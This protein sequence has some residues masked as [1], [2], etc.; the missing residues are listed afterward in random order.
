VDATGDAVI[1]GRIVGKK[2]GAIGANGSIFAYTISDA[3]VEAMG[4]LVVRDSIVYSEVTS[5]GR[6]IVTSPQG[7]IFG[8]T[9]A[10]LKEIRAGKI[11][12]DF[13]S[14]TSTVVGK[15]FLTQRRLARANDKIRSYEEMLAKID[16]IKKK[17]S[18]GNV[19]TK[20][21]SAS[22]QDVYISLLQKEIRA[23][24]ELAGHKRAKEKLDQAMKNFLTASIKVLEELN[25]P[26]KV[27][28]CEAVEEIRQRLT[29]VTLVLD[30]QN[31]V[32]TMENKE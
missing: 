1:H 26:V 5:N 31:K 2:I 20:D 19:K 16:L 12:S 18:E 10:A 23:R 8:G 22:Q 28:I 9:V 4:D 27:Q 6:I 24:E 13:A 15:D 3:L 32:F 25:P 11:G 30:R 7:A 29:K 17:L 14:F 21:L